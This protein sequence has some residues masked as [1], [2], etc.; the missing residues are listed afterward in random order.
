MEI[1]ANDIKGI[2]RELESNP[3]IQEIILG[4][5]LRGGDF[6]E[7]AASDIMQDKDVDTDDYLHIC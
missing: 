1:L 5:N 2:I 4:H 3:E 6:L 7:A